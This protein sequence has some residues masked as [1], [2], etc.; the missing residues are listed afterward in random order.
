MKKLLLLFVLCSVAVSCGASYMYGSV[1][2]WLERETR[3]SEIEN[4]Q[5]ITG[6]FNDNKTYNIGYRIGSE[7][8][9]YYYELL[10]KDFGWYSNTEGGFSS[11]GGR[12]PNKG[13]LYVSPKRGVAIYFH[14]IENYSV[15]K[16]YISD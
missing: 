3:P 7:D 13:S 12:R 11:S 14:P 15:Y 2:Y 5:N 6:K 1:Q 10:M 9:E 4:Q 8:S 16:A